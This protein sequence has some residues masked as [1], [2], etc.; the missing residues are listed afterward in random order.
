MCR[1]SVLASDPQGPDLDRVFPKRKAR[2]LRL[3][4]GR[5]VDLRC[6]GVRQRHE[7]GTGGF[8]HEPLENDS[9]DALALGGRIHHHLDDFERMARLHHHFPA[10][11]ALPDPAQL[12]RRRLLLLATSAYFVLA[13]GRQRDSSRRS[14]RRGQTLKS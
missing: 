8:D 6:R 4:P 13:S 2:S 11:G 5:H 10:P 3:P 12:T 7:P 14:V 1:R 9:P